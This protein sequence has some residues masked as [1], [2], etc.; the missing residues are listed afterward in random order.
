MP[1]E[2]FRVKR[3][4]RTVPN[5]REVRNGDSYPPF[6]TPVLSQHGGHHHLALAASLSELV[7][8]TGTIARLFTR[9][10]LTG[11]QEAMC[12]FPLCFDVR[13]SRTSSSG[14]LGANQI[15]GFYQLS[16]TLRTLTRLHLSAASRFSASCHT[17]TPNS[18]SHMATEHEERP[19]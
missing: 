8:S 1:F 11:N 2:H 4:T 3:N 17:L 14:E 12:P 5:V 15:T 7:R 18:H 6:P 16:P 19:Q 9:F 13:K 10:P